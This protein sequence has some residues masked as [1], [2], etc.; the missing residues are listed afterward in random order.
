MI[1]EEDRLGAP[2]PLDTLIALSLLNRQ[3]RMSFAYVTPVLTRHRDYCPIRS[4]IRGVRSPSS[5]HRFG[6]LRHHA[7]SPTGQETPVPPSPQ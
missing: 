4:A 2:L 1:E 7:P 5:G 3:K 6:H